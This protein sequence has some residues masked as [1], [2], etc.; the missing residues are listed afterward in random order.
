MSISAA[1]KPNAT[2]LPKCL[3]SACAMRTR[4]SGSLV[5]LDVGAHHGAFCLGMLSQF[6]P[7]IVFAFEPNKTNF[8]Q[9][10]R[11]VADSPQ[12]VCVNAAVGER[13]GSTEFSCSTDSATGSILCYVDEA[14]QSVERAQVPL[15]ALDTFCRDFQSLN[16]DIGLIKIDTQG[17]DLAVLR[18]CEETLRQHQ[19]VVYLEFIY[20]NLYQGQATP[21]EIEGWM[22]ARGYRLAGLAK[23]HVGANGVLAFCDALF[24]PV[25]LEVTSTP[26]YRQIDN[27]ES[28]LEQIATL[29]KICAERLV[30]IEML[31]AEVNRLRGVAS[32]T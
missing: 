28:W 9:L 16:R 20:A 32:S 31:D 10:R 24:V 19:P 1:E 14:Q 3:I 11:L 6:S 13:N 12:I 25:A 26:P 5:V 23:V 18:G 29:N 2:D 15:I 8:V 7:E 21:L 22:N 17:Y 4:K 30:V 27:E